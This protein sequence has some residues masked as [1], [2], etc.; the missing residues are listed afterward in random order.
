MKR[1]T[2]TNRK[3]KPPVRLCIPAPH[4]AADPIAYVKEFDRLNLLVPGTTF[5]PSAKV[6]V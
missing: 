1:L 6:L 2:P 5:I 3:R 4:F